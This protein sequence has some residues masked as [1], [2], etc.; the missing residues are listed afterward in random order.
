VSKVKSALTATPL[1]IVFWNTK[2]KPNLIYTAEIGNSNTENT[3]FYSYISNQNLST[4]IFSKEYI[5]EEIRDLTREPNLIQRKISG[6]DK[7]DKM[8]LMNME[9]TQLTEQELLNR[10]FIMD[11]VITTPSIVQELQKWN[12]MIYHTVYYLPTNVA[13]LKTEIDLFLPNFYIDSTQIFQSIESFM[14]KL[15]QSYSVQTSY[16]HEYYKFAEVKTK[17]TKTRRLRGGRHSSSLMMLGATKKLSRG[18]PSVSTPL[19]K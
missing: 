5:V 12:R 4:P 7:K 19:V 3:A 6:K 10:I 15:S 1:D 8:R 14:D 2:L 13:A 18:P 9:R 11:Q 16:G 17:T